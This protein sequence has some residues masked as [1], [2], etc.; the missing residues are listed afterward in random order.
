MSMD[1]S[2]SN[3]NIRIIAP[4]D[5][6]RVKDIILGVMA[7]FGCIGEGYSSSDPEVQSMY[8]AFTN[9]QSAFFVIS[10]QE[11]VIYGCGGIGP[12]SGGDAKICELKKMYFL[13]ELRGKGLGQLMIDTCVKAARDCGYTQCYLETLEAMTAANHLYHKNGFRKLSSHMGSTGH[14]GCDAYF[15][16]YL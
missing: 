8:Q 3:Y 16:K 10:D 14:S 2:N 11:N 13:P 5:N 6:D 12:L 4:T 9:D 1:T 15:V 7:D